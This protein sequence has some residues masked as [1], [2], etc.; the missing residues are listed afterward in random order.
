[1]KRTK[2]LIILLLLFTLYM[3][4]GVILFINNKNNNLNNSQDLL[5]EKD[6]II[7]DI[8]VEEVL[9]SINNMGF[10]MDTLRKEDGKININAFI[11]SSKD[12]ILLS[13]EKLKSSKCLIET[14]NITKYDTVDVRFNLKMPW[15]M[16]LD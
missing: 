16:D 9:N 5:K 1:M 8:D 12:D 10:N 4:Q 3:L 13:L 6:E 11:S 2:G 14:Y 15:Y 7:Y